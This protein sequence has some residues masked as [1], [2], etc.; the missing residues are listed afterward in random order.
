VTAPVRVR[1]VW[2][3]RH[4]AT[5][6]SASGRHT[7]RT[8]VE[9]TEEGREQARALGRR[10]AGRTFGAVLTSPLQRAT[11]TCRLAGFL[12]AARVEPDLR[13]WDYGEYEGMTT[14]QIRE[15]VAGWTIWSGPVPGGETIDEVAA[16]AQHVVDEI[17]GVEG[18]VALFAHGHILRVLTACWLDVEPQAGRLL[19]LDTAS[20]C[21]LGF[22][23]E[24]R[25]VRNWNESADLLPVPDSA[26]LTR[27]S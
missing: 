10:L 21:I 6:W 12:D 14:T 2:L 22:E 8:D 7:G 27:A 4:G 26:G 18:D 17:A 19:A 16:R 13:E 25:V 11:E 24:T 1:Q 9:L 5:D 23:H 15:R 3:V 20:L